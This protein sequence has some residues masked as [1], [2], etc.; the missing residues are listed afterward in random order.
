MGEND[1]LSSLSDPCLAHKLRQ[2]GGNSYLVYLFFL[3]KSSLSR[4]RSHT[5]I[6]AAYMWLAC[7]TIPTLWYLWLFSTS[8]PGAGI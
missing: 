8:L 7:G 1:T 6:N 4:H 3:A 2:L 5:K